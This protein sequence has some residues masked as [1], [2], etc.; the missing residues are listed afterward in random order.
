LLSIAAEKKLISIAKEYPEHVAPML[1]QL[2]QETLS[3]GHR[4]IALRT[5]T[6]L[7]L[8]CPKLEKYTKPWLEKIRKNVD[9]YNEVARTEKAQYKP[10]IDIPQGRE[11]YPQVRNP[12]RGPEPIEIYKEKAVKERF[13]A[14][15]SQTKAIMMK[16]SQNGWKVNSAE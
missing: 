12:Y 7:F 8:D 2:F 9:E 16:Q 5:A 13:G 11:E 6:D 4:E 10:K 3:T 15:V 1:D 14:S